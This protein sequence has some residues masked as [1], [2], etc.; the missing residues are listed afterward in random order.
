MEGRSATPILTVFSQIKLCEC[1]LF[2]MLE[3][4]TF[5]F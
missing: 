4:E 1:S 2:I 3:L 5:A